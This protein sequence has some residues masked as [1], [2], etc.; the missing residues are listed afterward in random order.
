M[1]DFAAG[2]VRLL[3]KQKYGECLVSPV[4]LCS[5]YPINIGIFNNG[6]IDNVITKSYSAYSRPSSNCNTQESNNGCV[7]LCQCYILK[8]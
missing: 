3:P 5:N 1:C 6:A 4:M 8:R 2:G 7:W